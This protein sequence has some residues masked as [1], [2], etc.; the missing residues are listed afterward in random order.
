[1][2]LNDKNQHKNPFEML[3][4]EMAAATPSL[5][6]IEEDEDDGIELDIM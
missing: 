2:I 1:M 4:E 6:V 3:E 5:N